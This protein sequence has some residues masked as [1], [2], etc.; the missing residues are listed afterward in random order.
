MNERFDL[1]TARALAPLRKNFRK[2]LENSSSQD[3]I[4]AA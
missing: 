1:I 3:N 4:F 2:H